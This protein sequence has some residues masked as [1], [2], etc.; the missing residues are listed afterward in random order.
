M[1][2]GNLWQDAQLRRADLLRQ[3][4]LARL[5]RV[6]HP[7]RPHP[8]VER[9]GDLLIRLGWWLKGSPVP[10]TPTHRSPQIAR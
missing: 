5:A 1:I 8:A 9:L 2:P 6:A 3:A 10:S 7:P 4:E